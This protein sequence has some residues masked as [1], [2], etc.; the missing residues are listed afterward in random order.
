MLVGVGTAALA[1]GIALDFDKN[2]HMFEES[3]SYDASG[4]VIACI[5]GGMVIASIPCFIS[6]HKHKKLAKAQASVALKTIQYPNGNFSYNH[7]SVVSVSIK[8]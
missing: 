3:T 5:G 7:Q 6:A 8:F 4:I 1:G 2:F